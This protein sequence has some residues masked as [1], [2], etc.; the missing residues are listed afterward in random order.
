MKKKELQRRSTKW[1]M[2][3]VVFAPRASG[4]E[5]LGFDMKAG[6]VLN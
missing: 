1:A 5:K 3:H 2:R 6:E 4:D